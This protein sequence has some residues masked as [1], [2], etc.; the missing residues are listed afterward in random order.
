MPPQSMAR[1]NSGVLW[2]D[3]ALHKPQVSVVV[4]RV[5]AGTHVLTEFR[6]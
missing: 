5:L 2:H 4:T 6:Q 1:R 3:T